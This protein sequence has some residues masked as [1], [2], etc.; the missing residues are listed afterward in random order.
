MGPGRP[1]LPGAHRPGR[2]GP[3]GGPFAAR[4]SHAYLVPGSPMAVIAPR[5]ASFRDFTAIAMP[6]GARVFILTGA[7]I[8][9]E[10]GIRTFRDASG[11][12]EQYRFE[13]VASP[14]GWAADAALVWRF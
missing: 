10:S 2:K 6:P 5:V 4:P 12:W 7:G 9:A 1:G 14:E 13:E 11:L 3:E 8:S